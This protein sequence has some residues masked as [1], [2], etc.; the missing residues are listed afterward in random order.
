MIV[1][2]TSFIDNGETTHSLEGEINAWDINLSE[3][4]M[5]LINPI[6]YNGMIYRISDY[7][8]LDLKIKYRL[9]TEC[10]RCLKSMEEEVE[11]RLLGRIADSHVQTQ[12]DEEELEETI[13]LDKN[14][15]E[16]RKYILEQ[17]A[18]SIPIKTICD[19]KCKGLCQNCGI[20]L[21]ESSCDCDEHIIDPRLEKL[22][23][24]FPD[25]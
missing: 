15:I 14:K 20:D 11:T 16:L 22:K 5:E 17:V 25:Q 19:E 7:Y 24:L 18:S 4:G 12:T 9:M 8:S 21:N 2:L 3:H 6:K 10:H 13:Y 1:D 23:E